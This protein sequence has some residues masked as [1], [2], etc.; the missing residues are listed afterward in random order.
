MSDHERPSDPNTALAALLAGNQRFVRGAPLHPNQDAARRA[1]TATGQHPFAVILGCSDS[2][3]AAEIVFDCGLG[4]LFVIRTA[5][6]LLG[7]EVLASIEFAITALH[8]PLIVVLGHD[9]CGAV[10]AACAA[11]DRGH[12]PPGHLRVIVE[13]LLLEVRSAQARGITDLDAIGELHVTTTADR[14]LAD[15]RL[16]ADQV[17]AGR[18]AVVAATYSLA[19]GRVRIASRQLDGTAE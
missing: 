19:H 15:S 10:A 5:G 11:H 6:H 3:V 1:R 17:I 9:R 14:L 13:R 4:D 18:C 2:R 16:V 12:P 8:T 7:A